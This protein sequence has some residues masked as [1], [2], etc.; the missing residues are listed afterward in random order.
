MILIER[1]ERGRENEK[2]EKGKGRNP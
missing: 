2:S 1:R